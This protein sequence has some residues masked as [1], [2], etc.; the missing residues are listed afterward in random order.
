MCML[1]VYHGMDKW[2]LWTRFIVHREHTCVVSSGPCIHDG[3]FDLLRKPET[4][5]HTLL[6]HYQTVKNKEDQNWYFF[7][8]YIYFFYWPDS[9][10]KDAGV[11]CSLES[12]SRSAEDEQPVEV[13]GAQIHNLHS[14]LMP[15]H[16]TSPGAIYQTSHGSLRRLKRL[17][18]ISH[19]QRR[20]PKPINR[21][22]MCKIG[23]ASL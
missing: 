3:S 14:R 8:S 22:F 17:N 19:L 10:V 13:W 1:T 6:S 11:L 16:V 21:T 15:T 18:Y 23:R 4:H 12:T 2:F 5:S 7:F 9:L 20:F